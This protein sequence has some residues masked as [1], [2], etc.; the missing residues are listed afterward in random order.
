MLAQ[1]IVLGIAVF[2][3]F[4]AL[5]SRLT[6]FPPIKT[7]SEAEYKLAK[8]LFMAMSAGFL[9]VY[10]GLL[11]A[12]GFWSEIGGWQVSMLLILSLWVEYHYRQSLQL[13][14][15]KALFYGTKE[16]VVEILWN[17]LGL[18]ILYAAGFFG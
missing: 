11:A 9:A 5:R 18:V 14:D 16:T 1:V 3:I 7:R 13:L 6:E 4:S 15:G 10:V 2:N 17:L 12:G 8:Y